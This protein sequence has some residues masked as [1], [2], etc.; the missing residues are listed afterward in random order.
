M[1][2]KAS[3]QKPDTVGGSKEGKGSTKKGRMI[4]Q[5]KRGCY[6]FLVRQHKSTTQKEPGKKT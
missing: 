2:E 1:D 3:G 4:K 5:Y 6:R